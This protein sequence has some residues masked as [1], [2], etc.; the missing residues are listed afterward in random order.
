[1]QYRIE[2]GGSNEHSQIASLTF[3]WTVVGDH[4]F[5]KTVSKLQHRFFSLICIF[6][7]SICYGMRY[8]WTSCRINALSLVTLLVLLNFDSACFTQFFFKNCSI[9][10]A[11][12]SVYENENSIK[13][14]FHQKKIILSN[15]FFWNSDC[16]LHILSINESQLSIA[17]LRLLMHLATINCGF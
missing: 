8:D 1:M 4:K 12:L 7:D 5:K 3:S 11:I 14:H 9:F 15:I 2:K 10:S 6:M 16:V 13:F 17:K